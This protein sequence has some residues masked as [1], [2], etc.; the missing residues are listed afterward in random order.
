MGA[1]GRLGPEEVLPLSTRSF[2]WAAGALTSWPPLLSASVSFPAGAFL[3]LPK[4]GTTHV[5]S[6][7]IGGRSDFSEAVPRS[8]PGH[9]EALQCVLRLKIPASQAFPVLTRSFQGG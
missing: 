3:W 4:R 9:R 1:Q 5:L 2:S 6:F 8:V 7:Q